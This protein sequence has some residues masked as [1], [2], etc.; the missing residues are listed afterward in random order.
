VPRFGFVMMRQLEDVVAI[1]TLGSSGPVFARG[2]AT[3]V[4]FKDQVLRL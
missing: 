1:G 3:S 4:F 2:A